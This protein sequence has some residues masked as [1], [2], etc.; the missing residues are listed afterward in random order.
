MKTYNF[1]TYLESRLS[2]EEITEIEKE[3]L[4]EYEMYRNLQHDVSNVVQ[5]Y[6]TTNHMG[7]DK[8]GEKLG[9][10]PRKLSKIIKAEANLTLANIAQL[11]AC[12]GTTA[13]IVAK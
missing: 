4:A 3:A 5:Q 2:P 7:L 9:E 12:M 1:N 8:L 11:F 13:H 6:M 10:T